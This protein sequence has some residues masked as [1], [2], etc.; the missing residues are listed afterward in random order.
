MTLLGY[1]SG[2]QWPAEAPKMTRAHVAVLS[3]KCEGR[4]SNTHPITGGD[5]KSAFRTGK[6]RL[7]SNLAR[8]RRTTADPK[9]RER[10]GS[11]G[12]LATDVAT[13]RPHPSP[14]PARGAA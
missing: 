12:C 5:F 14:R 8:E 2:Y 9:G 1:R 13:T 6:E 10:S 7:N 3:I 11:E 4:D